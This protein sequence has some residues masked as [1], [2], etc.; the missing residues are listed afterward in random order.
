MCDNAWDITDGNVVCRQLGYPGAK[1]ATLN[2]YFPFSNEGSSVVTLSDTNC[3]GNE[4]SLALCPTSSWGATGCNSSHHAGVICK[5]MSLHRSR[6]SSLGALWCTESVSHIIC[7]YLTVLCHTTGKLVTLAKFC[8]TATVLSRLST[9]CHHPPG[10]KTVSPGF[11][12][13]SS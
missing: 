12:R 1:V 5:G 13:I 9:T 11:W 4:P 8:V 6:V 3:T 7:A 2:S 10:M